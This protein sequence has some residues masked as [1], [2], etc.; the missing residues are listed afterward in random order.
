MTC[1]TPQQNQREDYNAIGH[2]AV[3]S[4][5]AQYSQW[6]CMRASVCLMSRV[7]DF[8]VL[9]DSSSTSQCLTWALR[10]SIAPPVLPF[11]PHVSF[12]WGL[13]FYF[14]QKSTRKETDD[15]E[16]GREETERG[17]QERLRGIAR[18]KESE[19]EREGEKVRRRDR[20]EWQM[21]PKKRGLLGSALRQSRAYDSFTVGSVCVCAHKHVSWL[22]Y[23][24]VFVC[25]YIRM[26]VCLCVCSCTCSCSCLG[27]VPV[28]T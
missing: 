11:S 8:G 20:G 22:S 2:N 16:K 5:Q 17:M 25:V 13:D 21:G 24:S 6:V 15:R 28:F 23:T 10:L 1:K 19:E 18:R 26:C 7:S 27:M 12:I 3:S 14:S 9:S 4:S